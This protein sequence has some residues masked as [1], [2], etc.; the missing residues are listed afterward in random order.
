MLLDI[1]KELYYKLK[2]TTKYNT[3]LFIY[4]IFLWKCNFNL[5]EDND[6]L[7]DEEYFNNIK[8][9]ISYIFNDCSKYIDII[10]KYEYNE[11]ET[12]KTKQQY[13]DLYDNFI[14]LVKYISNNILKN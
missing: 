13:K 8:K 3:L 7:N 9:E 6:I 5:D 12:T 4:D 1:N 11:K 2:T 10:E 14:S